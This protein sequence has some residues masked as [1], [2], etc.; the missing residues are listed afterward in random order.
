VVGQEIDVEMAE[1]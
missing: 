1:K